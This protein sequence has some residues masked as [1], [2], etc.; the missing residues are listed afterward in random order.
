MGQAIIISAK[1]IHATPQSSVA[2]WGGP[3]LNFPLYCLEPGEMRVPHPRIPA[4][5]YPLKLR[6]LGQKHLDYKAHYDAATRFGP[7]WHQGMIEICDVPGRTAIEF[8]VG[9]FIKDT[10]GCSLAGLSYDRGADAEYRVISSRVAYERAYPI[11][12]DLILAGPVQIQ[13][14][15]I[16]AIA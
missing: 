11:L 3:G 14:S 12:R 1:R 4:G 13:I 5:N 10:L 2:V 16:G 9:N 8:H 7:E 6:T 15:D